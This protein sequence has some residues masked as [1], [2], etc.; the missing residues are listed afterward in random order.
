[1]KKLLVI[2]SL[3]FLPIFTIAQE[4]YTV[5][6]ETLKLNEDVKG[7]ITLL[8]NIIDGKYRFFI[9]SDINIKELKNSKIDNKYQEEYKATLGS[10]TYYLVDYSDVNLTLPSLRE[11]F[12]TYNKKVDPNYIVEEPKSKLETN[13]LLH[14]GITNHPF[15]VNPENASN[16]IFGVEVEF[17]SKTKLPNHALFFGI[18]HALSSKKFDFSKTQLDLGYRYRFINKENFNIYTNLIVGSYSYSKEFTI[19]EENET[20]IEDE[21]SGG[22]LDAPFSIGI[23]ADIKLSEFSFLTLSYQDIFAIFLKNKDNFP[24]HF[25]IGYKINL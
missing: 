2:L 7:E 25:N 21:I 14:G 12:N 22:S 5:D 18:S 20:I 9:K 8:W 1:M 4:S 16:P 6:G 15:V 13:L 10:F 19:Y 11:F 23:G 24:M 3:I 17:Y